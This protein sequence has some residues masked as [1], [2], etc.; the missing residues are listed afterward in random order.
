MAK[1]EPAL[2]MVF[3]HEG[4]LV[5]N[6][7][8]SGSI[9]NLGISFRF[10]KKKVKPDSTPDD[11]KNLTVNDAAEI[12]RRFWWERYPFSEIDSQLICNRLFD[13]SV[14]LGSAAAISCLQRAIDACLGCKL[15]V[16][17]MLGP[18]T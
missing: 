14:N 13:L 12:Y 6:P 2:S 7:N 17:G 10:Y 4:G 5:D 11:I 1:L 9:T 3:T 16:D 8:D 18:K 15:V